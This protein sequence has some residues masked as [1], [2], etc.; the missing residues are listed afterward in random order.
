[1]DQWERATKKVSSLRAKE[2]G[3]DVDTSIVTGKLSEKRLGTRTK[4]RRISA[5]EE[6]DIWTTRS[7]WD[8]TVNL[9][10]GRQ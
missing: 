1:M 8:Y 5:G 6:N 9:I 4:E 7:C 3:V 10:R 2:K